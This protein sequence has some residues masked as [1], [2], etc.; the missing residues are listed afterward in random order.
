LIAVIILKGGLGLAG[1]GT[2][3]ME[4]LIT[5]VARDDILRVLDMDL[6]ASGSREDLLDGKALDMAITIMGLVDSRVGLL[7]NGFDVRVHA[8]D[9]LEREIDWK[10]SGVKERTSSLHQQ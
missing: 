8:V 5:N 1:V 6:G 7:Q 2:F 3:G 4:V 10:I 9:E